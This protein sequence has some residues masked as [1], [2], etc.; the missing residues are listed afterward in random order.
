MRVR[1]TVFVHHSIDLSFRSQENGL[2]RKRDRRVAHEQHFRQHQL[3]PEPIIQ[4]PTEFDVVRL[5]KAFRRAMNRRH[6]QV[7]RQ[8]QIGPHQRQVDS[9]VLVED[10]RLHAQWQ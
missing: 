4:M 5:Q 2:L 8:I 6:V 1:S 7:V 3:V 10:H 9:I